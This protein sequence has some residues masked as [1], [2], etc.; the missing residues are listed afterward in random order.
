MAND[1]A[2]VRDEAMRVPAP[3]RARLAAD[4]LGSL[5][6]DEEERLDPDEHPAMA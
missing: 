6:G 4:L 5:N 2:S 3:E 1:V